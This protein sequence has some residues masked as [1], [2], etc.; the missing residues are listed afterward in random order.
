MSAEAG[1]KVAIKSAYVDRVSKGYEIQGNSLLNLTVG[2][3]QVMGNQLVDHNKLSTPNNTRE[4]LNVIHSLAP[5]RDI[6]I[7]PVSNKS[8]QN[9]N[10][11][12]QQLGT[13]LWSRKRYKKEINLRY[14]DG[15]VEKYKSFSHRMLGRNNHSAGIEH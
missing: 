9:N 14:F 15:S 5:N 4:R 13:S 8:G 12:N 3:Q 2:Q 10:S 6:V 11:P 7:F 1:K